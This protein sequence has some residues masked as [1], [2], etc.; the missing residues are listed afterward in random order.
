MSAAA[1]PEC[2][3]GNGVLA[4]IGCYVTHDDVIM[5]APCVAG[6][7]TMPT[8]FLEIM[9]KFIYNVIDNEKRKSELRLFYHVA[10]RHTSR[11]PIKH[12]KLV[13]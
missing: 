12:I 9:Q 7:H 2:S 4:F 6:C 5:V 11:R 10:L 3:G 1:L 13:S 8:F